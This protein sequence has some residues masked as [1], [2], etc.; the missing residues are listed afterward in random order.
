MAEVLIAIG[1]IV[2][3]AQLVVYVVQATKAVNTF[4][5]T[6]QNAPAKICRVEEKLGNLKDVI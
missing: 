5:R 3:I 4:F 6:V 2:S 1:I